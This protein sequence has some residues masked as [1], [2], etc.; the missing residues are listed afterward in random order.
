VAL[1]EI[2]GRWAATHGPFLPAEIAGRFGL[3]SSVVLAALKELETEGRVVEGEFRPGAAGREWVD[4]EVLRRIR[5]RSLAA[6]RRE[7]EPAPVD[8]LARFYL[9]WN[10][11]GPSAGRAPVEG[12]AA[13]DALYEAIETLQGAPVPASVLERQVLPARLAGYSPAW[14]DELCASGEVVWC[15]AGPLGSDDGWI[16]L[17]GADRAPLLLPPPQ[18]AELSELALQIRDVLGERGALF[19]RQIASEVE[20][21]DDAELLLALWELAWAGWSTND[22]LVPLRALMG[23]GPRRPHGRRRRRGPSLP[24][25][26]GP[27]AGAGRWSLVPERSTD[28]TRRLHAAAEQ[29]LARHG[30]VTR[31]AV[32]AERIEGGFAGVYPVFK[33]MEESGRCRRGYFV[34]GLGG[35]QFAE[36]GAV[37]RM[38]SLVSLPREQMQTEVLA[39]TDPANPYGAALEWPERESTGSAHRPGRKAGAIVVL[40]GGRLVLYVEKGGRSLLSFTEDEADLRPAADA[41]ALAATDGTLGRIQVQKADGEDVF[42]SPLAQVLTDTG[43]R[44]SSRGLRLRA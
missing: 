13:V 36:A 43:F 14:L 44:I 5:R 23:R 26:S 40:V 6:Y 35:A 15:G 29:M 28:A 34:D 9:A 25:R 7:I 31:G 39:A 3:G 38:R 27:P 24:Q 4:V 10:G 41:L 11:I 18:E 12:P 32:S 17:A 1:S 42:D 30:I 21:V 19:F 8:A 33:A 2:V 22:T 16:V 37:D 20:S